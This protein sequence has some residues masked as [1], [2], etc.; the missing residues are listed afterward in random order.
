MTAPRTRATRA[1]EGRRVRILGDGLFAGRLGTVV[2]VK[3]Q[4]RGFRFR[5]Q[6]DND[7]GY[8]WWF[9]GKELEVL[10]DAGPSRN[11]GAGHPVR[12]T[13]VPEHPA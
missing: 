2:E 13:G 10:P 6:L 11:G 12:A 7:A 4:G 1:A 3:V 5:V 9:G 8:S